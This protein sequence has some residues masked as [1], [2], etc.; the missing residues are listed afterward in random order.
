MPKKLQR[1]SK[2]AFHP[3]YILIILLSTLSVLSLLAIYGSLPLLSTGRSGFDL[4]IK[5]ILWIIIAIIMLVGLIIL[6]VDRLFTSIKIIYWVL[7]GLLVLLLVDKYMIDLPLISPVNGT[8]AWITLPGLGTIQPS[9]F[10][11]IALLIL[12]AN[13][14]HEHNQSKVTAT[15]TDD[16]KLFAKIALYVVPAL[17]LIVA[18]PDTG[19]PIIIALG[20]LVMLAVSGIRKE[21]IFYSG[22]FL[23][24][25]VSLFL[26]LFFNFEAVL[27]NIVG[28]SYRLNR[29]YGWLHT[30]QYISSY[31]LQLYQSLLAV[32]SSGLFGHG[33]QSVVINMIEPQNDFIF[34]VFAQDFGFIGASFLILIQ[35]LLDLKIISIAMKFKGRREKYL[36]AGVIGMLLFQ[37]FQNMGMIIGLMPITGI[38]LPFISAGGSSLLSY[39]PALAVLFV[40]SSNVIRKR[41]F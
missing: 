14:I 9:E 31:G 10:M 24:M 41:T 30:E 23:I 12:C 3:D 37:Q 38:T 40:M 2:I 25:S 13:I 21:W 20:I 7:F 28:A 39:V 1:P 16:I 35:L 4:I 32:G 29:L 19:I 22:L 18:Q 11:K 8:T 15:F 27:I 26:F 6:G 36:I 33:L 5:Q 34:A 17:I